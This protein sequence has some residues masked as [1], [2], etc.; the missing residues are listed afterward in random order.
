MLLQDFQ[1]INTFLFIGEYLL[2][3]N[4]P[5]KV[6]DYFKSFFNILICSY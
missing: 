3:Y 6:F 4:D 1:G 2:R 5:G